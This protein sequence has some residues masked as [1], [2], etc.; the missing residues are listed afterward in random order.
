MRLIFMKMKCRFGAQIFCLIEN[1]SGVFSAV[2]CHWDPL[3]ARRLLL[4][5][6]ILCHLEWREIAADQNQWRALC[7]S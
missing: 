4:S 5:V 6:K 3:I 2:L 7:G 1:T